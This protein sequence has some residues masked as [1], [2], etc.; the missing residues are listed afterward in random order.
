MPTLDFAALMGIGAVACYMAGL[1]FR[2]QIVLRLLILIGSA[3]YIVYYSIAAEAPLWT[4]IAGT[5]GITAANLWGLGALLLS[6]RPSA[7]PMRQRGIREAMGGME[8]GLFRRLMRSGEE[9]R[10]GGPIQMTDE[11]ARPGALWFL[12]SG[13]A[14]LMK[15]GRAGWLEG[16]CFVGEVSWLTGSPASAEVTALPGAVLVRWERAELRRLVR[17]SLRLETALEAAIAVD[18]ARKVSQGRPSLEGEAAGPGGDA[19]A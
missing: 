5:L 3:F 11:N 16:P 10:A 2:D 18:M 1:L 4:A 14:R 15:G 6:R 19:A 8:P 17:R 13:R 12:V 9:M 7:V